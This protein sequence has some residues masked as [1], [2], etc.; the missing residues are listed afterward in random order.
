MYGEDEKKYKKIVDASIYAIKADFAIKCMTSN[1]DPA[2]V[3]WSGK[4]KYFK[5]SLIKKNINLIF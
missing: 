3:F 5:K 1:I 4:I 2:E